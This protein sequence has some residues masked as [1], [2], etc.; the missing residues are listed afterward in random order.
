MVLSN[1]RKSVSDI[2]VATRGVAGRMAYFELRGPQFLFLRLHCSL[3]S[4]PRQLL[5]VLLSFCFLHLRGPLGCV[6]GSD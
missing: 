3:S 2:V 6:S 1:G 5:V 4:I